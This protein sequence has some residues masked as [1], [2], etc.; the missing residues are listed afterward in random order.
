[1]TSLDSVL[2]IGWVK[3]RSC[4]RRLI[5]APRRVVA[6]GASGAIILQQSPSPC[7]E[8][9]HR[10]ANAQVAAFTSPHPRV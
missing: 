4:K 2:V 1:M 3:S 7:K 6:C 10:A 9:L 5:H 8:I